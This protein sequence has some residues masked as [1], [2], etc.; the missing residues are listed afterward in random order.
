MNRFSCADSKQISLKCIEILRVAKMAKSH[1]KIVPII[2][3]MANQLY[4]NI[5]D[6]FV[7]SDE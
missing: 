5:I 7:K 1:W 3:I 6:I 4:I 2:Y